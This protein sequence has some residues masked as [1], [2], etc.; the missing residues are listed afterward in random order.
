MR[1]MCAVVV[2]KQPQRISPV[3]LL[4][5]TF[6][7]RLNRWVFHLAERADAITHQSHELE[8]TAQAGGGDRQQLAVHCQSWLLEGRVKS[9]ANGCQPQLEPMHR[10][11]FEERRFCGLSIVLPV[12]G[13]Q[14]VRVE[15]VMHDRVNRDI[16]LAVVMIAPARLPGSCFESIPARQAQQDQ[17]LRPAGNSSNPV[18]TS[19]S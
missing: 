17:A 2:S 18:Y 3:Y 19:V 4:S 11:F 12:P 5:T 9:V 10:G 1:L 13:Q 7:P 16:G 8:K 14:Q 15:V 6:S